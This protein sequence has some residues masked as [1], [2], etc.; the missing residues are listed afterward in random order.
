LHK[1][2]VF[3]AV[4]RLKFVQSP[5]IDI[6]ISKYYLRQQQK[7]HQQLTVTATT[8]TKTHSRNNKSQQQ[9]QQQQQQ[10]G[11][12]THLHCTMPG[13]LASSLSGTLLTMTNHF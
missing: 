2:F 11:F 5:Y 13:M 3:E 6:G 7:Q 1:L 9:Q 8:S 12:S 4:I 10:Q